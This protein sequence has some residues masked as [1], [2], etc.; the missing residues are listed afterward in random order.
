MRHTKSLALAQSRPARLHTEYL[1]LSDEEATSP[2]A[3]GPRMTQGHT[4]RDALYV[5][6]Y[7]EDEFHRLTDQGQL[8]ASSTRAL[9]LEAG[10]GPGMRVLDVGCGPGDVSLLAAQRVGPTGE[11]VGLDINDRVLELARARA[12]ASGATQVRFIQTDLREF[13]VDRPFDA[14]VG[15]FVLMYLAAPADVVRRVLHHVGPG[16]IVAFQDFQIEHTPLASARV[17]LWEQWCSW[18]VALYPRSGVETNMGLRLRQTFLDAGLPAP[19]VHM[20]A[21]LACRATRWW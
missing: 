12:A 8:V 1:T 18:I 2:H 11:V 7:T 15:R 13:P 5:P 16:G 4:G 20:D 3:G 19:R 17:P 10:I 21:C 14:V 6:G 9:L